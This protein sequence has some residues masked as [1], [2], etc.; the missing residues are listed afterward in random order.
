MQPVFCSPLPGRAPATASVRSCDTPRRVCGRRAQSVGGR[1]CTTRRHKT[2]NTGCGDEVMVVYAWHPWAGRSIRVHDVVERA[3]SAAARCSLVG[4]PV[5]RLQEIPVWMLDA[6]SCRWMSASATPAAT[7]SALEALRSLLSQVMAGTA[8]APSEGT[9]IASGDHHHGGRHA[10]HS[11][12]APEA[13]SAAR[14]PHGEPATDVE[15]APRVE[16]PAG[17]G[18]ASG[19]RVDDPPADSPCGRRGR[20]PG[21]RRR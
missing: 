5:D 10:P 14:L 16:R 19:N 2:H 11:P 15:P 7:L 1:R 8:T 17:S 6:A 9:A 18:A 12:P 13:G 3:G 21:E 4:A 20:A